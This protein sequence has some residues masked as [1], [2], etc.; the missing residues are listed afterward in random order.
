[1]MPSVR[2]ASGAVLLA[3]LA[4]LAA[5]SGDPPAPA[6]QRT[7]VIGF[8]G[9]DPALAERWMDEGQLPHFAALRERGHYQR[10]ATSNPPQSPVAWASFAT[11]TDPGQHGIFDFLRRGAGSYAPDFSIAEQLPPQH[12]LELFGYR[13][14][15]DAGELRTRRQGKPLWLAAEE[16]G[17]RATVL[18]VP[19]TY[20]P[21]PIQHMLAG[22]GV[23][24]L[25]GTQG[26]YTLLATRPVPNADNGGRVLLAPIGEDG[27]VQTELEGPPSPLH[28]DGRRLRVPLQ[29]RPHEGG[30]ELTLDGHT[31]TVQTGQWSGWLRLRFSAGLAGSIGGMTR[32]YLVE[33]FPRPLLYLAPLQA[34]PNEPALPLSSPPAYAQQLAQRIGDY[35]TLGMPEETWALNQGH[36]DE[37]A[38]LAM[39]ATTLR[40]GEAM[41]YDALGRRDSELVIEVFVQPDRVSHMFWR[42]IDTAHPLHAAA[43]ATARQAIADIY[44]EADRVLGEVVRRLGPQDRLI[45]LS[46]HGFAGFRREVHLNRWLVEQGYMALRPG[47]D[48]EQPLFAAVDWSRTRAYAL[49]LNGLFL[50]RRGRE[51]EGI[52]DAADAAA[53]KAELRQRL[54]ELRDPADGVAA[55]QQVDDA[56]AI[57]SAAQRTEAPDLL[58]GYAPGYRASWQTSLGAVPA[59]VLQDNRQ[60]WSGD[61]CIAPQAVPGV[62]F[63]SFAL[64]QPVAGIGDIAGLIAA[65]RAARPAP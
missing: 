44:R 18:R 3:A 19:V 22:M 11:G 62:L 41:L 61:H 31:V 37:K 56:E 15:L 2:R 17:E 47:A 40:E 13:L 21:D 54:G 65:L 30:A 39:V 25:L 60:L 50:N 34:D 4:G 58:V 64:P 20:P 49:G 5:C 14:A 1:M 57:Y 43:S 27:S 32:A 63:T 35:H 28:V 42:G 38:W 6:V 46:D 16:A 26:T 36:L 33:A 51:P 59:Q 48:A 12:S 7:V 10:L 23:P 53:L 8:D 55:V 9:F 52:V 24:D 29:L 45:V